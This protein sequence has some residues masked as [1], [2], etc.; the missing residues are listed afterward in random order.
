MI[1]PGAEWSLLTCS[2]DLRL[3]ARAGMC[4]SQAANMYIS[5]HEF[6]GEYR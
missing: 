2:T 5:V 4:V 1:D 3:R 6:V